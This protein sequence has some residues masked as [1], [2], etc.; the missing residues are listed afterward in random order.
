MADF[1]FWTEA[2]VFGF[3]DPSGRFWIWILVAD[4][5]EFRLEC[6]ILDTSVLVR[7][8]VS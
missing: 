6:P 3:L 2:A 8:L 5:V 7:I 1:G 4:F